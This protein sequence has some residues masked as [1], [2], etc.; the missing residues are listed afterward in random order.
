LRQAKAELF[1]QNFQLGILD[2]QDDFATNTVLEQRYKGAPL[3]PGTPIDAHS[4]I[5]LVL[6]VN[7]AN[8]IAYIPM[9]VGLNCEMAKDRITD[10][11]LNVGIVHFDATVRTTADSL[12]AVVVRQDPAGTDDNVRRMGSYVDLFL[13]LPPSVASGR[14][15]GIR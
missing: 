11:S 10:H 1:S 14:E 15:G 4:V 3:H 2:Y 5:D 7:P 12:A 13:S 9:V 8:N 6:G